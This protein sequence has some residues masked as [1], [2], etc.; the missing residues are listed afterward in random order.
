[1]KQKKKNRWIA[2]LLPEIKIREA[3]ELYP[4]KTRG[5][6][7]EL[8][9]KELAGKLLWGGAVMLLFLVPAV[10][11]FQSKPEQPDIIR[12][13]PGRGAVT[14]EISVETTEGWKNLT[15]EVGSLEYEEKQIEELHCAAERYLETCILGENESW[16]AITTT[17]FFPEK[18]Q[19]S[20]GRIDW[21]TDAPWLITSGGEVQNA[22][23]TAPE[24][25]KITAKIYYGTEYR[26]FSRVATVLPMEYTGE[27]AVIRMVQKELQQQ[28]KASRTSERFVLPERISGYSIRQS[29]RKTYDAAMFLLILALALPVFFYVHYFSD[30]D[31][32]R[33]K[34]K[35]QAESGYLNFVTKLS[36]MMAAG[37]TVRQAFV[38]LADE[39]EKNYGA[40]HML[41]AE[42]KVTNREMEHGQSEQE[43][44]EA[45][46]RRIGVLA[47]RR[48][49][50]LL[51]QNVSRGVQGIRQLLLIEAKEVM[52]QERAGIIIRGAQA[53][54]KLLLPMTGLLFLVFAMLLV[55]AFQTF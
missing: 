31:T 25:V 21:S 35:E 13:A 42:L 53:G 30:L 45:F 23:L 22:E 40:K 32:K 48:L 10:Y 15:L 19:E 4:G 12:P 54:T 36:L 26:Y 6:V 2:W 16:E 46:G 18:L 34:R 27:E 20:G 17:L 38:R 1:V 9:R 43:V 8:L 7:K 5:E 49:A 51:S 11:L 14:E 29:G 33:K 52:A 28:E 41:T 3:M 37:V 44:Y 39:Y 50:S 24:Q 47:Y 55:P